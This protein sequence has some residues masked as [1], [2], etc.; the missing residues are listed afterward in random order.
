MA[1]ADALRQLAGIDR[2][3]YVA[4]L[5]APADTRIHLAGLHLFAAEIAAIP[6][7]VR[8]PMAGMV[9]LQWWRD[10]LQAPEATGNPIADA[11]KATIRERGLPLAPFLA[12]LDAREFDLYDDPMPSRTQLEGYLG[13]TRSAVIQLACL[14]LEPADAATVTEPAGHAGCALGLAEIVEGL[15]NGRGRALVPQDI[16][17]ALGV[18]AETLASS[19]DAQTIDRVTAALAALGFE[20]LGKIDRIPQPFRPAFAPVSLS[21]RRLAQRTPSPLTRQWTMMRFALSGRL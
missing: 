9:R 20:H 15:R 16:L 14:I 19:A 2:D 11:L 18:N 5:T 8:E 7:R 17:A 13:E 12:L 3:A 21:R 6:L 1:A 10:A 4:T